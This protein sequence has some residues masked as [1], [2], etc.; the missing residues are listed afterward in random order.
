M[1][2]NSD[3]YVLVPGDAR[4]ALLAKVVVQNR[5]DARLRERFFEDVWVIH[6]TLLHHGDGSVESYCEVFVTHYVDPLDE[7]L[8]LT[9]PPGST[10]FEEL[11]D[12]IQ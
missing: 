1:P 6:D 9:L 8:A 11:C 5:L 10:H 12:T 4:Q 3:L 7:V 2:R